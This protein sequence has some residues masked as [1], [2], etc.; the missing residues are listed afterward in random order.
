MRLRRWL[1]VPVLGLCLV[2]G[3][4]PG[5]DADKAKHKKSEDGK[6]GDARESDD[7]DRK[8]ID[9]YIHK[10][11]PPVINDG[12]DLYN[13]CDFIGAYRLYQGVLETLRPMLDHHRGLQQAIDD[14]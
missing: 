6:T 13:R 2:G 7:H 14:A 4:L 1:V 9:S 8:L 12:A 3:F 10:S 5:A 11:L